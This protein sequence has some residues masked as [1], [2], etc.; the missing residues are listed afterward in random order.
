VDKVASNHFIPEFLQFPPLPN[1]HST[2]YHIQAAGSSPD[3][4]VDFSIDLIIPAPL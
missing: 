1:K 4:V 3:E 2:F